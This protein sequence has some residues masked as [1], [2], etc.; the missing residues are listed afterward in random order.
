MRPYIVTVWLL[1][2][3][4]REQAQVLREA[5][6]S[7]CPSGCCVKLRLT[8]RS[9]GA[10]GRVAPGAVPTPLRRLVDRAAALTVRLAPV[11]DAGRGRS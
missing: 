5:G 9:G 3:P 4:T 1:V 7:V 6:W 11:L 2:P 8:A 10:A